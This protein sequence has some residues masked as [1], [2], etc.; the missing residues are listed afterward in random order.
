MGSYVRNTSRRVLDILFFFF[1]SL[2][3]ADVT[4]V[5][6]GRARIKMVPGKRSPSFRGYRGETPPPPWKWKSPHLIFKP[7]VW[8]F[9]LAVRPCAFLQKNNHMMMAIPLS[10]RIAF[11]QKKNN[12]EVLLS[13]GLAYAFLQKTTWW[14]RFR[15]AAG[16]LFSKKKNNHRRYL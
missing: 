6:S 14:W 5:R 2:C 4:P 1:V 9:R 13:L 3:S 12:H 11:L 10:R 15:L 16:L 7:L 8:Y